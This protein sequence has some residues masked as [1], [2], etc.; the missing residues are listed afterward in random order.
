MTQT[1]ILLLGAHGKVS[2]KMIPLF[3]EKS[4]SV[5]ALIRNGD[6][7]Q[8]ND[9]KKELESI[10]K[11]VTKPNDTV[12]LDV[13]YH[14]LSDVKTSK[15]A[16]EVIKR[17]S[18][19]KPV[20]W[21]VWS[22][23]SGGK[24]DT[25]EKANALTNAI[26]RDA[27]IAFAHAA[28]HNTQIKRYLAVS[29][30]NARHAKAAWWGK[31]AQEVLN[32]GLTDHW[33]GGMKTYTLAKLAADDCLTVWGKERQEKDKDFKFVVLRPGALD[34][35]PSAE[36]EAV[37]GDI[38]L[39]RAELEHAKQVSRDDVA[40]TAVALLDN[41]ASGYFDLMEAVKVNGEEI[42][43]SIANEV[44]RVIKDGEKAQSLED[45]KA[46]EMKK[47]VQTFAANW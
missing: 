27:A 5:T 36:A 45:D 9:Q 7:K 24:G 1:H 4:W 21:I 37:A 44:N 8:K 31:G 10:G 20:T 23:G 19:A 16:A 46:D 13:L 35:T 33:P 34:G 29:A 41:G 32:K 42:G 22:A 18:A 15:D 28:T 11:K 25:K 26:D 14:N 47:T 43:G 2:K 40:K 3:L 30:I 17:A 12:T 39:G 38:Q 6:E